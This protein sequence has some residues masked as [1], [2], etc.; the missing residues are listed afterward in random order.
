MILPPPN[1]RIKGT[2]TLLRQHLHHL[3]LCGFYANFHPVR[4]QYK[5]ERKQKKKQRRVIPEKSLKNYRR[6]VGTLKKK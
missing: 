2:M 1:F 5:S 6:F 3:N 4:F